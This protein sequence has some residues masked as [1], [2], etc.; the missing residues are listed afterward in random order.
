MTSRTIRCQIGTRHERL[1]TVRQG[2][3]Q[4]RVLTEVPKS[5]RLNLYSQ[6]NDGPGGPPWVTTMDISEL[7]QAIT[8]LKQLGRTLAQPTKYGIFL[9]DAVAA[10]DGDR[11]FAGYSK[12]A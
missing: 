2:G 11:I 1:I 9:D 5:L 8:A 12:L 4:A 6:C 10:L 3:P 7:R